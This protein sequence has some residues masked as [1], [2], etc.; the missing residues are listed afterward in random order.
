MVF[1]EITQSA[2][3]LALQNTREIDANLVDAQEARRI[4][5]RLYGYEISPVLWRKVGAGTSAG[6]VQ[7]VATRLIV[8]KEKDRINFTTSNYFSITV[9]ISPSTLHKVTASTL[10]FSLSNSQ[11]GQ[12]KPP[13]A[14]TSTLMESL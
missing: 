4:F 11:K 10:S 7:S 1:H 3:N 12:E 2:I 13:R 8:D 9:N 5:D 14:G 6:R